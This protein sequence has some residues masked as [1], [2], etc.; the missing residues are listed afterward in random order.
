MNILIAN[1]AHH[2]NVIRQP[3]LILNIEAKLIGWTEKR[4]DWG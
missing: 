3:D 2:I 1:A 4:T